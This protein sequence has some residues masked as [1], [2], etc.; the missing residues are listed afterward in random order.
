MSRRNPNIFI[1]S[2]EPKMTRLEKHYQKMKTG[3]IVYLNCINATVKEIEF[4][5][6]AIR[7][8]MLEPDRKHLDEIITPKFLDHY[9]SGEFIAP[10]MFYKRIK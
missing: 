7:N 9:L 5:R 6:Y 8:H 10:Q 3:E 4:L 1:E 2:E